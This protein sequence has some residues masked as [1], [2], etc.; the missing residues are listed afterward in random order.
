MESNRNFKV[1]LGLLVA[2]TVIHIIAYLVAQTEHI[3]DDTW[4]MHA[5][6]HTLQALIWIVGLDATLLA[7][8]LGPLRQKKR[9]ALPVLGIGGLTAQGAYFM[10]MA[11][12]PAG[13][14]PELSAHLIMAALVVCFATGLALVWREMRQ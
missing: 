10:T 3:V 1:G 13:R 9:W 8:I 12:L 11:A 14:P 4:P 2:A 6:F 7:T 5:R